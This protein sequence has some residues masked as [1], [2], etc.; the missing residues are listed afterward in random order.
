[1]VTDSVNLE[2]SSSIIEQVPAPEKTTPGNRIFNSSI[3]EHKKTLNEWKSA[4]SEGKLWDVA[5]VTI[6][7]THWLAIS[8]PQA[9]DRV[10]ETEPL[11][12]FHFG[13]NKPDLFEVCDAGFENKARQWQGELTYSSSKTNKTK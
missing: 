5:Y 3:T 11:H 12:M 13:G 8:D 4:L 10:K 9:T 1:M 7:H 6:D 2:R